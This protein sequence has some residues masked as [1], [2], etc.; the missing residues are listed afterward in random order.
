MLTFLAL[1]AFAQ[2]PGPWAPPAEPPPPPADAP[3]PV[4]TTLPVA[5]PGP[6]PWTR[7]PPGPRPPLAERFEV[8]L[9]LGTLETRDLEP[10]VAGDVLGSAG[11]RL[12]WRAAPRLV[13]Y[14]DWQRGRV[15][16]RIDALADPETGMATGGAEVTATF[17]SNQVALGARVDTT[18][19]GEWVRP[20][21]TIAALGVQGTARFD[22]DAEDPESPGQVAYGGFTAGGIGALGLAGRF[23][24]ARGVDAG[25][26]LW[27]EV[28]YAGVLP[29]GLGELGALRP[30]G[31]VFRTGASVIF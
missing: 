26:Q 2:D 1:A 9:A 21:A 20:Y 6:N 5:P 25:G 28:G 24:P 14:G 30:G 11:L 8:G 19:I 29:L 10:F 13:V 16:S 12:G 27:A 15:G 18:A 22:D 31:V 3:P 4:E 23:A 7:G 17:A